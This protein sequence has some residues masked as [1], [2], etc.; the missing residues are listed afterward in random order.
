MGL[1]F[2]VIKLDGPY[3]AFQQGIRP[4]VAGLTP[5]ASQPAAEGGRE[6]VNRADRTSAGRTDPLDN[7]EPGPAGKQGNAGCHEAEQHQVGPDTA[8]QRHHRRGDHIPHQTTGGEILHIVEVHAGNGRHAEHGQD[9]ADDPH[10][11]G[12]VIHLKQAAGAPEQAPAQQYHQRRHQIGKS[13]EGEH[14][15]V[16]EPGSGAAGEVLHLPLPGGLGPAGIGGM[17]G[18]QGKQ[19]IR[20]HQGD[21]DQDGFEDP[22]CT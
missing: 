14:G 19:K 11:Q 8:K 17:I 16:G 9:K 6:V 1:I 18:Q 10:P 20:G 4:L 3:P 15:D 7:G 5:A 2:L 22:L 12:E 21:G 13:T